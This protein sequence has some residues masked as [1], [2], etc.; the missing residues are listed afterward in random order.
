MTTQYLAI[1]GDD[2]GR[3]L[4]YF[5]ITNNMEALSNFSTAFNDAMYWLEN[6]VTHEFNATIVFSGGDNL[7]ARLQVNESSK[8]SIEQ[9]RIG[10]AQQAPATLS[11]GLGDEPRQAYLALKLAKA[12][13]KNCVKYL[14]SLSDD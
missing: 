5:T 7:L 9:L 14:G 6:I 12:S 3:R 2:V 13:G 1:D 8:R 4:E 11:I 10:F